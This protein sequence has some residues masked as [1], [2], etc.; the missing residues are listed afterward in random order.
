MSQTRIGI[1]TAIGAF[2]MWGFAA[3]FWQE[4]RQVRGDEL[5]AHRALWAAACFLAILSVTQ[6]FSKLKAALS[7]PSTRRALLFSTLFIACNWYTFVYAV[8][9]DRLLHASL[10][11]FTNPMVNVACGLLFFGE[12]LRPAQKY[13]LALVCLGIVVRCLN[14]DDFPWISL[15]LA[16]AFAA[17]GVVRKKASVDALTGNA[18][19]TIIMLPIALAYLVYLGQSEELHFLSVSSRDDLFL[20]LSGPVTLLPMLCFCDAA[21]RIP[22]TWLGQLQYISPTLQFLLAI[23]YFGETSDVWTLSGFSLVWL[24][25]LISS[26]STIRGASARPPSA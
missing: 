6:G 5:L 20:L 13:G 3:L 22:M 17:Y 23:F 12:T 8:Q 15:V 4:I 21:R 26:I 7:Q 16:G 18:A 19:E 9:T 11:Y 10:G 25:L 2:L 14:V 24:G 1:L